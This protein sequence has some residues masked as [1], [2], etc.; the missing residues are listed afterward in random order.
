MNIKDFA[1]KFI[2]A[3][4]EAFQKGDFTALAKLEDPKIVFHMFAVNQELMGFEADKQYIIGVKQAAPG[5]RPNWKYLTGEGNL[6]VL[7]LKM[8]G[9]KFTGTVPGFPPPTG[10]EVIAS[11][12][13]IFQVN[14][15]RIVEAWSNGTITG[16]T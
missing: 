15:G 2:K 7:S 5:C 1:E 12:L 13:W 3:E 8:S 9:A 14:K 10:K 4:D 11:S 16:L 6:F